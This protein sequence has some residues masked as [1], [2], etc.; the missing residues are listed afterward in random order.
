MILWVRLPP[1]L[2]H[3]DEVRVATRPRGPTARHLIDVQ[4]TAVRFRP[5]LLSTEQVDR[6]EETDT[7]RG[8]LRFAQSLF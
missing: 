2:L 4:E 3:R 8:A 7:V 6:S 5:G 1:R